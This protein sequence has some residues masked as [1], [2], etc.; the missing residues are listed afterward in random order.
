MDEFTWTVALD[1]YEAFR[2]PHEESSE[3]MAGWVITEKWQSGQHEIRPY[4]PLR[5]CRRLHRT[6]A[7]TEPTV[8]PVLQ[9]IQRYGFLGNYIT[10]ILPQGHQPKGVR[11]FTGELVTEWNGERTKLAQAVRLWDAIRSKDQITLPVSSRKD[12]WLRK[13]VLSSIMS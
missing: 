7:A 1:G 9:F 6:F 8:A 12:L 11:P 10:R 3:P 2:L 5:E 4:V 13:P